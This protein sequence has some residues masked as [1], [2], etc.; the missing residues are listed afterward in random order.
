MIGSMRG[1]DSLMGM[2]DTRPGTP[3]LERRQWARDAPN[4]S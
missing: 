3:Y 4:L 2:N 1:M